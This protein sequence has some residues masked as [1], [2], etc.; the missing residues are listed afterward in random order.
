M[1]SVQDHHRSPFCSNRVDKTHHDVTPGLELLELGLPGLESG[2][3]RL[4]R[5]RPSPRPRRLGGE[6][7]G[8]RGLLPKQLAPPLVER[9]S[10]TAYQV[11]GLLGGRCPRCQGLDGSGPLRRVEHPGLRRPSL[12]GRVL[13]GPLGELRRAL[14][15]SKLA[16]G[17]GVA[18]P[19]GEVMP[20]RGPLLPR[21]AVLEA[22]VRE[23]SSVFLPLPVPA[24]QLRAA[25]ISELP[26]GCRGPEV[27]LDA[28]LDRPF[29]C[30][31]EHAPT[32]KRHRLVRISGTT[33]ECQ[34]IC[35]N[36]T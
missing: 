10:R 2:D 8:H 25:G 30:S 15:V 18:P 6:V 12:A 21:R 9:G 14:G 29:L 26:Y 28:G 34:F 16:P 3:V 4:G 20:D 33:P 19:M 24:R 35:E 31:R 13:V 36:R 5:R 7:F 27:I 17:G 22:A 32:S 23:P 11:G 1:D